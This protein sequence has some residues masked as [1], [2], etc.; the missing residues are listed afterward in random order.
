MFGRTAGVLAVLGCM[1]CH[2]RDGA[3]GG[4]EQ[5]TVGEAPPIVA[6]VAPS[7]NPAPPIGGDARGTF[8]D[9]F[10][11]PPRAPRL[12]AT[13]EPAT[14]GDPQANAAGVLVSTVGGGKVLTVYQADGAMH[15]GGPLDL[16]TAR[17][18]ATDGPH[19]CAASRTSLRCAWV[20]GGSA[21]AREARGETT[22]LW[23][24]PGLML[25][26]LATP[27]GW[28]KGPTLKASGDAFLT[29]R[30]VEAPHHQVVVDVEIETANKW[31]AV[32]IPIEGTARPRLSL[33]V[34]GGL[35]PLS[36]V[37]GIDRQGWSYGD[38]LWPKGLVTGALSTELLI[39]E[40]G[41]K[42][43]PITLPWAAA[44][45]FVWGTGSLVL[46]GKGITGSGGFMLVE[47]ASKRV[48]NVVPPGIAPIIAAG[49]VGDGI[50]AIT[51]GGKVLGWS[52]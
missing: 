10:G 52:P 25:R 7:P 22:G 38:R 35:T 11:T 32:T 26:A 36:D 31:T 27:P 40:Q 34:D 37:G 51:T 43:A 17:F 13:I 5:Q 46:F 47:L 4:A 14:N 2:R 6:S 3:G 50:V 29:A 33:T 48:T 44:G 49:R 18:V 23:G 8:R 12:L 15:V 20:D 1:A 21:T 45:G 28:T 16:G 41:Q 9:V 24:G 39:V 42:Q 30:D 19:V